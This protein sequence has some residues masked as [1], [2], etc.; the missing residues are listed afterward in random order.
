[1]GSLVFALCVTEKRKL[2][3]KRKKEKGNMGE[4][5]N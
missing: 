4:E 5:R 1:V 3:T 2:L